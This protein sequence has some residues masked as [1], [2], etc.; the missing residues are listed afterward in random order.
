MGAIPFEGGGRVFL[1][2]D[3][4]SSGAVNIS[5]PIATLNHLFSSGTVPDCQDILDA[6][7]DGAVNITDPIYVL[8]FLFQGGDQIE[9]PWPDPGVDPTEDSLSC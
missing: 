3:V 4:D 5:D 1:R 7:D 8:R 2:G 9:M 6:N